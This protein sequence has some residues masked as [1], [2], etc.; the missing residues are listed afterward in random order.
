MIMA[1]LGVLGW[2]GWQLFGTTWVAQRTHAETVDQLERQWTS[3]SGTGSTTVRV[4]AGV[5]TAVLRV[6]AFG[7]DFAVPILDGVD[8][9]VLAAGM[10]RF[11]D[12][13]EAG[14]VGN[15][16]LAGHRITH[17]EPLRDLPDLE[18]G[19]RIVIETASTTYTYVLD[20]AGDALTVPFTASWVLAARPENPDGGVGP[21][22]GE[23]R[24]ITL[25]TCSELFHTDDRLVAF[26]HLESSEPRP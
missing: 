22:P 11:P 5:A 13:A 20:T 15:Y 2:L 14:A 16:S 7:E 25:T 9:D 19:D 21:A 24:L 8:D 3:P 26:G 18:P 17:G 4:K 1:G 23:D 10:G 6:P 12:S